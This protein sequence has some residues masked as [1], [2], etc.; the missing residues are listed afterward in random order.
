MDALEFID[1]SAKTKPAPLFA[2][3]GD[4]SFLRRQAQAKLVADLLE[5]ADPEFSM[6]TFAGETANWSTIKSELDTLPFIGP[7]RVVLIEQADPFVTLCRGQLEK[8]IATEGNRGVLIL[9]V[10]S[11]PG[12]TKLAKATTATTITAKTP[13]RG[14]IPSW[15]VARAKSAYNADIAADA[16]GWLIELVGD[17]LGQIDQEL[18]KLA[19][20]AGEG[21]KITRPLV[22]KMVGRT[23]EAETFKIFDAI[24]AGKT[25]DALE[26]LHRLYDQGEAA[27]GIFSGAF[28]WQLRRLGAISRLARRSTLPEAFSQLGVPPFFRSAMEQQLRH[29]GRSR[30][31]RIFD[32]VVETDLAMKGNSPLEPELILER[33]VV[34]LSRPERP[35]AARR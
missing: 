33:L 22:D 20:F 30:M 14:K 26:I 7:R 2:L 5:D 32:W 10:K 17:S 15:T 1:K 27:L 13:E 25:A 23:R 11:W 8:Y 19:V 28:S 35:P 4:E 6:T 16:A 21:K 12:N 31:D 9:D 29:L 34:K 3:T 24:G 18:A